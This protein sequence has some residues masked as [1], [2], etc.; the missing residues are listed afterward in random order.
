MSV[1]HRH[2]T[3]EMGKQ[4]LWLAFKNSCHSA[5]FAQVLAHLVG[6]S[7][8]RRFLSASVACKINT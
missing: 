5:S 2:I 4:H 7:V 3:E 6:P 1:S 8:Q